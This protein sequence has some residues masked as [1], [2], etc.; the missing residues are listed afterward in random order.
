MFSSFLGDA[1]SYLSKG[2]V[3]STWLPVLI[4]ASATVTVYLA[5]NTS[6][7]QAWQS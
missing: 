5:G 1:K 3:L 7:E 6:L 2:F 4:F